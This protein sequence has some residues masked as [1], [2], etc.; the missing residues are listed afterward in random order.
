V[1]RLTALFRATRPTIV[2]THS[3]KAGIVGRLAARLAGVPIRVHSIHGFG[4]N[5]WQ[6][7][8]LR[9]ALIAMER[10]V[11]PLTTH[12]IAVSRSTARQ[13]IELGI[14]PPDRVTVIRSGIRIAEFER[15]A[16]DQALR[17]GRGLR[18]DLGLPADAPLVGMVACFKPQKAPLDFVEVAARVAAQVPGATFVLVGDGEL[19]RAIV[20]RAA[21]LGLGPRLRLLGW[22]RDVARVM[23]ALDVLLHTSLWE[24]LPR[25]LPEAIAAG[26]PVVATGVDGATDILE[27][28]V[29]G[30]VCRPHDIGALAAGVQ[31]LLADRD[32]RRSLAARARRLLPEFDIDAMVRSQEELYARLLRDAAL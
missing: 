24:G 3:S 8:A 28:G 19:R 17:N 31:R 26:L 4:F 20:A 11:A 25:V 22:R 30:I 10:M 2:H 7:A 21:A 16:R 6:P 14:V 15:A 12:F 18:G 9:H 29:S 1:R 23:S 32:L 13:G 5:A 27:D